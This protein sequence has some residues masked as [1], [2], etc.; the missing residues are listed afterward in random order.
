MFVSVTPLI[1][2]DDYENKARMMMMKK[3]ICIFLRETL[4]KKNLGKKMLLKKYMMWKKEERN[5]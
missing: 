1:N 2:L 5:K 4:R 3:T